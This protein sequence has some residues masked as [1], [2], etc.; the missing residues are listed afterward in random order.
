METKTIKLNLVGKNLIGFDFKSEDQYL[1]ITKSNEIITPFDNFEINID[2]KFPMIRILDEELFLVVDTRTEADKKNCL[3]FNY[4]GKLVNRFYFGDGIEDI[5]IIKN[6]IV[7]S[8]FD[9]GVLEKNGPNNNG[10]SIFNLRGELIFGYNEK[11][12]RL[13]IMDCYCMSKID[14]KRILF[15]AYTEFDLIELNLINHEEIVHKIPSNLFGSNAMTVFKNK[16]YF[17]SPYKDKEG[18]YE[19]EIGQ[20]K[21]NKIGS[22]KGNLRSI[23]NGKFLAYKNKEYTI[24]DMN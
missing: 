19:W 7:V 8:Y 9:E 1:G 16:I 11:H 17:H 24:I 18:I 4:E 23:Q 5:L 13:V 3:I 21:A 22:Y 10:L 2:I 20:E 6:K 12:G 14:N 15:L